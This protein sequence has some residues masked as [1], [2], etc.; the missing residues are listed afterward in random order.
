MSLSSFFGCLPFS[1]F[2]TFFVCIVRM[3]IT[4]SGPRNFLIKHNDGHGQT[5][6]EIFS[7]DEISLMFL[8]HNPS[9]CPV[10]SHSRPLTRDVFTKQFISSLH[11]IVIFLLHPFPKLPD[12]VKSL[13]CLVTTF[14]PFLSPL[15]CEISLIFL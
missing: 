11:I 9:H 12:L 7:P 10:T 14:L 6:T 13:I 4:K 5:Q 15:S 1:L 2:L 8:E 3:T